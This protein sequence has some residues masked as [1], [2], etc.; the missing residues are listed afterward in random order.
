MPQKFEANVQLNTSSQQFN[1][2]ETD[3]TYSGYQGSVSLGNKSGDWSFWVNANHLDSQGQPM[4]FAIKP[5]E[6]TTTGKVV[7]G[8]SD[9]LTT[10]NLPVWILGTSTQYHT[11]QDHAKVKAAYNVTPTL[12]ASYTLGYWQNDSKGTETPI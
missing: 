4:V 8:G 1:I 10:E 5:K 7:T 12:R 9:A 6:T 2:Y 11:L 3:K